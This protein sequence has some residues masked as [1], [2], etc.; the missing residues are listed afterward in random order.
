MLIITA[1]ITVLNLLFLLYV[2][3]GMQIIKSNL[4]IILQER[5]EIKRVIESLEDRVEEMRKKKR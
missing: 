5:E 2:I 1:T 4:D 3:D